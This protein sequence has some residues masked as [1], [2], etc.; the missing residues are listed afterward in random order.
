[1]LYK[2][3]PTFLDTILY[4]FT[5]DYN[6]PKS[7]DELTEIVFK[8]EISKGYNI[9]NPDENLKRLTNEIFNYPKYLEYALDFLNQEGL[10]YF[11]KTKRNNEKSIIITSKGFFKIRTQG[12]AE[13]IKTDK[14]N[15]RLQRTVWYSALATLVITIYVQF[16]K[17]NNL[18]NDSLNSPISCH[19]NTSLS[20]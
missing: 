15:L 5:K 18:S 7:L 17:P 20:K 4:A 1:M 2:N 11:D 6:V 3:F 12:F 16:I 14:Y 19:C 8:K 9:N 10:V 13:K